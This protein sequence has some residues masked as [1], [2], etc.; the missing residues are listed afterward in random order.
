MHHVR[1][2]AALV[3]VPLLLL[4]V[5]QASHAQAVQA[6]VVASCGSITYSAGQTNH[7]TMDTTGAVCDGGGATANAGSDASKAAAVQGC[8]GCK[9][10]TFAGQ[11]TAVSVTPTISTSAYT[12]GFVPGGI[13]SFTV[14]S[15]GTINNAFSAFGSGAYVGGVDYLFFGAN[16]TG[17]GT[18]DH[19]ALAIVTADTPK[20][21]GVMHA[22][23]CS[24]TGAATSYCQ[25]SSTSKP[26]TYNLGAG[27]TLYVV[28][29][30]IGAATFTAA[31]DDK[32]TLTVVQ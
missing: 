17:G 12:A 15:S 32:D 24:L 28:K 22:T 6:D 25:A 4:A 30:I 19:A 23:D 8:T 7:V 27:T 16:P 5:P 3:A 11:Y 29:Q 20:L 26:L 10:V 14:P 18:A 31:T 1:W 9:A 13:E 21:I 2:R